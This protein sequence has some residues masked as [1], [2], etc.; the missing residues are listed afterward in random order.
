MLRPGQLLIL[1]TAALAIAAA[2]A[3]IRPQLALLPIGLGA[4]L[5]AAAA[6]DLWFARQSLAGFSAH[7][8]GARLVQSRDGQIPVILTHQSAER[9]PLRAGLALPESMR[10][11][12]EELS[13]TLAAGVQRFALSFRCHPIKR[14]RFPLRALHVSV[15]SPLRLWECGRALPLG[16]AA[17]AAVYPDAAA[18]NLLAR[19]R[20]QSGLRPRR[21]V[22]KGRE[23][24]KLRE[25]APGDPMFEVHWKATAR[26]GAP[27]TKVFQTERRQEIYAVV[28]TSR[29]MARRFGESSALDEYVRAALLL[30]ATAEARGDKFGLI[31]F[32]REVRK[33]LRARA[34]KAHFAACRQAIFD[35]QPAPFPADF[36]ELASFL[37][38]RVPKRSLLFLLTALDE[39]A[40]AQSAEKAAA[41][42][43][44]RH[45]PVFLMLAPEGV[46]PL[47]TPGTQ[48]ESLHAALA[49]HLQWRALRELEL[50]F[51]R[52]GIRFAMRAPETLA[53]GTLDI[54]DEIKQRQL[55]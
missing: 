4:A 51:R 33:F 24:E 38:L 34:G 17:E 14:G 23:F 48:Y 22:G 37:R 53:A 26:R 42:L 11:A 8:P 9:R 43:A 19:A 20:L 30:G 16:D 13:F 40:A 52:H 12:E 54:Y 55:L 44:E 49:G 3:G 35:A 36:L 5:T 46:A 25:Y 7:S 29:L 10:C 1:L 47:F 45:L 27:V 41:L 50:S 6:L 39:P 21:Q 18:G 28:D 31:L 15:H 32:D 2:A